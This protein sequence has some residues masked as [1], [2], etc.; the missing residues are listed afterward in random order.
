LEPARRAF[1]SW[2]SKGG[3]VEF[4]RPV[5]SVTE[6]NSTAS[7]SLDN[8]RVMVVPAPASAVFCD[9][10]EVGEEIGR[11]FQP[12]RWWLEQ[13]FED[14]WR[15]LY[16]V[17]DTRQFAAY[18]RLFVSQSGVSVDG[19]KYYPVNVCAGAMAHV[20]PSGI[21]WE[22]PEIA[23]SRFLDRRSGA[24]SLPTVMS[25]SNTMVVNDVVFKF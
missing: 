3:P 24:F 17:L 7:I 13:R 12:E 5:V 18:F 20:E 1:V 8:G 6:T 19:V 25:R 11:L 23:K 14:K 9:T 2:V 10:A 21:L 16:E 4:D 22:I 15:S